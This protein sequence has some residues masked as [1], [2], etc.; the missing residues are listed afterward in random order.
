MFVHERRKSRAHTLGVD[1]VLHVQRYAVKRTEIIA[2]RDGV[3]GG[4][5]IA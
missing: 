5:R 2:A 3:V 1:E 4:F